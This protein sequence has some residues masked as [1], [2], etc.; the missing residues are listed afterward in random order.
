MAKIRKT[1]ISFILYGDPLAVSEEYAIRSKTVT[2]PQERPMVKAISDL[3]DDKSEP[4]PVPA[5]MLGRVKKLVGQYLPGLQDAE[6]IMSPQQAVFDEE[7][8]AY[9][10]TQMGKKQAPK[11]VTRNTV[12]RLSKQVEFARHIHHHYARLTL[13]SKGRLLKLTISR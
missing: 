13:D 2:R 3:M 8:H 11:Q 6:L 4:E 5:E 7:G 12:V 1:L 9:A 10:A